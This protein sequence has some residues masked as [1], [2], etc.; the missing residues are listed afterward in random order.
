MNMNLGN[1]FYLLLAAF[2]VWAQRSEQEWFNTL[3]K[4]RLYGTYEKMLEV[5]RVRMRALELS[6]SPDSYRTNTG[7]AEWLY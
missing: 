1:G 3:K 7:N 4:E 2:A 5:H 6:S